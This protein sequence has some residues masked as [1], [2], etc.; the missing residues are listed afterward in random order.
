MIQLERVSDLP[1]V[2]SSGQ[3]LAFNQPLDPLLDDCRRWQ[4]PGLQLLRH[5]SHESGV[6]HP[7]TCFHN[8]DDRSFD[9]MLSILVHFVSGLLSLWF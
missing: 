8:S 4:E 6:T 7:F 1:V 9:L 2:C 3:V 5:F